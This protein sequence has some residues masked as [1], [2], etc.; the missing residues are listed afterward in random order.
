MARG[1]PSK[2]SII[3][4]IAQQLF[5][6]QGYQ[7]TSIDLVVREAQ[8]SKPTVYNNFPSK[9]IL[10]QSLIERKIESKQQYYTDLL[11]LSDDFPDTAFNLF[12]SIV[13]DPFE[14]AIFKMFYG[15]SHK[16]DEQT[17]LLCKTFES[18][19]LDC[20]NLLC[21]Q[22]NYRPAQQFIISS[23]YKNAVILNTLSNK[24]I[25]TSAELK[26]YLKVLATT[27]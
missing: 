9:Q 21:E 17:I 12:H 19:L 16:L 5:A 3:L 2:K 26:L 6:E 7:A 8:V 10:I 25:L 22:H 15:E 18:Q 13:S 20:M 11:K 24:T 14:L 4:D 1:R 27:P 23:V